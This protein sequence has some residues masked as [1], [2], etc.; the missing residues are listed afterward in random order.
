M[1]PIVNENDFVR[2]TELYV[3]MN[4]GVKLY[5]RVSVPKGK[6]RCPIV[7]IRTPYEKAHNNTPY[8]I[9]LSEK[10][11][12]ITRGY[13]V[14]L[15]HVRGRGDSEGKC[16]PYVEREDG[17]TTL[18]FIRTLPFYDG[19]IYLY[20]RSYLTTVHLCYLN[21]KPADIKG[22]VFDIQTDRMY[23]RNYRNGCCYDFCKIDWWAS[24][25]KRTFPEYNLDG[26]LTRPFK[27]V[28]KRVWGEDVPEYTAL[29]LNDKNN[30]FW[31]SDPRENVIESIDFPVLFRDGWYDYYTSG[32]FDMWKRLP[33]KVKE[34]SAFVVGP[35][36]HDTRVSEKAALPLKSGNLPDGHAAEW[37]DSIR[38]KKEY[39]YAPCGKV[40]YYSMGGDKWCENNYPTDGKTALRLYFSKDNTLKKES[41]CGEI[42]YRYD[43]Q[44]K[45]KL[46]EYGTVY[47]AAPAG[48]RDD[49]I[50]FISDEAEGECDFFGN[51]RWN[52]KVSSSCDD[53]AFFMRVHLVRH[54]KAYNLT[55]TITSLEH[56]K[57]D[58]KRG[59][60]IQINLE[61][62]PI[63]FTMKKG[64][65]IRVD[66]SSNGSIYVPHSNL[67]CHWAKAPKTRI[68]TNTIYIDDAF[69]EILKQTT[70]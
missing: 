43:P 64:D 30:E 10:D 22:A 37:F 13:A 56:I 1:Y 26:T 4:D 53:T 32:M 63:G 42:S 31:Q 2:V 39:K 29:L 7:F 14:V 44:K 45:N 58:C 28:A 47:E 24:M 8:D 5:T 52:M 59:D 51:I 41:S 48:I 54:D 16:I 27:D 36:G 9:S 50:S 65:R 40:S 38:E 3:P 67:K 17:L 35:W 15:Q 23:F 57:P 55:E 33:I 20:G 25:M 11:D 19:E 68:A 69:I 6:D 62:P 61:T 66:I 34:K 60:I 46:F 21:T 70:K 18:D 12:Y 49:I